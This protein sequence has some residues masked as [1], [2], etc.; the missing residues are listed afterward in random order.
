MLKVTPMLKVTHLD[1]MLNVMVEFASRAPRAPTSQ[2]SERS[3]KMKLCALVQLLRRAIVIKFS[4]QAPARKRHPIMMRYAVS[5]LL[6]MIT[7]T[8]LYILALQLG[9]LRNC[10]YA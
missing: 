4:A 5:A 9:F 8:L 10:L 7:Y 1:P 2:G 3:D 6:L